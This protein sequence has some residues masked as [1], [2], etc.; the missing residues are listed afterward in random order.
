MRRYAGFLRGMNVGRR[1]VKGEALRE[2]LSE[3]GFHDVATFLASGNV[4]VGADQDDPAQVRAALECLLEAG[5]GYPVEVFVRSADE[6]LAVAATTPFGAASQ[7]HARGGKLQVGFMHDLPDEGAAHEVT[8][9][10]TDEDQI[11][12]VGRELYW[13]PSGGLLDAAL[14]FKTVER[15]LGGMTVRTHRTVTRLAAKFFAP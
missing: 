6:V 1:R 4:V 14:D 12:V 13:Q 5:L 10:S 9:H 2:I 7:A 8:T 11:A 15:L 3:G